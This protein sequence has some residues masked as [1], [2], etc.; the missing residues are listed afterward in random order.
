MNNNIHAIPLKKVVAKIAYFLFRTHKWKVLTMIFIIIL[1]GLTA[2]IDSILLQNLTDQ[3]EKY[4]NLHNGNNFTFSLFKFILIYALWWEFLNILWRMYDYIYLKTIPLIK[5]E[6]TEELYDYVQHHSHSFFQRN[7][8]GDLTSRITEGAR[9]I[10]MIFAYINEKIIRKVS[11]I[12]FALITMYSVHRDIATIF[13]VW[14]ILFVSISIYFAKTINSY[15][16]KYS[17]DKAR[18]AGKIVDS[19]AN[20]SAI[21]MFTAHKFEKKYIEHQVEKV[22]TSSKNMQWFMLKLRYAL[23]L[24]CT[25]MITSIVYFIISL[26]SEGLITI[27]Q[28]V[29]II[30]LCVAVAGD[31]WDLTQEFGDLFEEIGAFGQTMSL[32]EEHN[33][34]DE[35]NANILVVKKPSIEFQDVT[36]EYHNNNNIFSKK[37]VKIQ[38]YQKVGLAGFSG[39]GKTTFTNLITRLFDIE[40]GTI[41]IDGQDIK[42][43][44]QKSLRKN[45]SIIPQEPILFHRSILENIKYGSENASFDEVIKAAKSAY[46]HDFIIKL[47]DGYYTLCGERGNNLSGG[48]KQRII[49]ARAILKNAPILILDEATSSLDTRT[50]KLVHKSLQ[51]L[52]KKKTVIVIAHRLSTLLDMDRILVFDNGHIVEDGTHDQ[53][54]TNGK[55]YQQLCDTQKNGLIDEF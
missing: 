53:L 13:L 45:I 40:S 35:D 31:I 20:I 16:V 37:S 42:K 39:S 52:M 27:G 26:K 28:C 3:V 48:Q 7:L 15:S 8:A 36:F 50:E 30:T 34:M 2:S 44:T 25:L 1:S 29:L 10:E 41:F 46:I 19:I 49:I 22:V 54:K 38:P 6:V 24:S 23:G 43:V 21:R 12:I 5:A 55:L 17:R 18:V 4:S 11:V 51:N 47:P 14:F 33:I 9:S 32:F